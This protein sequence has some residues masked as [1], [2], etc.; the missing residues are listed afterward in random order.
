MLSFN[1]IRKE[2]LFQQ[3]FKTE[4]E[5]N[6]NFLLNEIE[7][8][9]ELNELWYI[10]IKNVILCDTSLDVIY[11]HCDSFEEYSNDNKKK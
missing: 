7:S 9:N 1:G 5:E 3:I 11:K 6:I 2:T 10:V 8:L 4:K